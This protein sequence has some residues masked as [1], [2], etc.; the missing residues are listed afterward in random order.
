MNTQTTTQQ[1]PVNTILYGNCIEKMRELP[2]NS[3]DFILTDPPYLVNYRDR[4]GRSVPNDANDKWLRPAMHEAYRVLK[5]DRVAIIF[6]SWTK[7][8][9]F[10]AA[11]KSAGFRP[12]G[13][14]VFRKT[15]ASKT[16]F[17]SYRHEQG[18]PASQRQAAAA[19]PAHRGCHR[20]AVYR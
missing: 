8:D 20:H 11:W 18:I 13:H 6:Y 4:S 12:V 17:L 5:Q 10:F 16:G 19:R 14:I 15:Y 2:A 9:T 7:V 3:M 1:I